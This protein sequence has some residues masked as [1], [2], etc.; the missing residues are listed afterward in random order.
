M[1]DCERELQADVRNIHAEILSANFS[2]TIIWKWYTTI[3]ENA[4][5]MIH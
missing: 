3:Q 1:W 5:N 4:Y 2:Y